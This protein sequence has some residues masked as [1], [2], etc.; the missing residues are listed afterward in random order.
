VQSGYGA[1]WD[2]AN[3]L[4]T[5]AGKAARTAAANASAT[6]I[7]RNIVILLVSKPEAAPADQIERRRIY[8]QGFA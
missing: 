8:S 7:L 4:P 1:F 6:A 2:C 3:E 5:E